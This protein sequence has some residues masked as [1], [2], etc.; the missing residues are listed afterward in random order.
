[1]IGYL[2]IALLLWLF[3]LIDSQLLELSYVRNASDIFN[4]MI[5]YLDLLVL[6]IRPL[7]PYTTTLFFSTLSNLF[8]V[9]LILIFIGIVKRFIPLFGSTKTLN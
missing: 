7:F 2:L 8:H 3:Q 4:N 5:N 6:Y 1:M 9:Y